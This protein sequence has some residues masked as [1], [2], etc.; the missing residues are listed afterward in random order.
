MYKQLHLG[1]NEGIANYDTYLTQKESM[2]KSKEMPYLTVYNE[3][4]REKSPEKMPTYSMKHLEKSEKKIEPP[5]LEKRET[6]IRE[7]LEKSGKSN[8]L[9]I[10]QCDTGI[11][12]CHSIN[13]STAIIGRHSRAEINVID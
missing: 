9:I 3:K 11:P 12:A 6:E 7:K 13:E 1:V 8:E 4:F 2:L 5:P 10:K